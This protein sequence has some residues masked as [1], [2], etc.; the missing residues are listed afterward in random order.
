VQTLPSDWFPDSAVA[1]VTGL[2]GAGA[3]VGA[4]LFTLTTGW[5]V[6]RLHSYTPILVTA[7]LLPVLGTALLFML[8][9][10]I[11]RVPDGDLRGS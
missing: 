2:G 9:G 3:G 1:S 11:R 4:M 8:G 6:D 10:T 7:A 5:V